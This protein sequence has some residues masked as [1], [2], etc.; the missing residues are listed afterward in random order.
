MPCRKKKLDDSSRLD[1]AEIARVALHASFQSL[2]QEKT[3]NS[4]HEQTPLSNDTIDSVLRHRKVGQGKD[5]SAPPLKDVTPP[6]SNPGHATAG[7]HIPSNAA[8]PRCVIVI[9]PNTAFL[10]LFSSGDHF[11]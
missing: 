4:A 10:K 11:H 2:Q 1:V 6:I 5:L 3:C 8:R 7:V 9:S